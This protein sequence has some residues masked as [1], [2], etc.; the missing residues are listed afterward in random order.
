MTPPLPTTPHPTPSVAAASGGTWASGNQMSNASGM[1]DFAEYAEYTQWLNIEYHRNPTMTNAQSPNIS[2]SLSQ[3]SAVNVKDIAG[4]ELHANVTAHTKC[5]ILSGNYAVS[6]FYQAQKFSMTPQRYD[7]VNNEYGAVDGSGV[8]FGPQ[9]TIHT[10]QPYIL[11]RPKTAVDIPYDVTIGGTTHS[12]AVSSYSQ[13]IY[14]Q[15]DNLAQGYNTY[16]VESFDSTDK[17]ADYNAWSSD[18]FSM[19]GAYA[20]SSE[21]GYLDP[22]AGNQRL[23]TFIEKVVSCL[24]NNNSY[25]YRFVVP[26]PSQSDG[27][28][29]P[30]VEDRVEWMEFYSSAHHDYV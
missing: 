13:K 5:V 2:R 18:R 10:T 1:L 25:R 12:L 28:S 7:K 29:L 16:D 15:G 27:Q 11:R 21:P 20:V 6:S 19:Y 8:V 26:Y 3:L 30:Q 23:S 4:T 24:T 14:F 22:A 17:Y 9:G